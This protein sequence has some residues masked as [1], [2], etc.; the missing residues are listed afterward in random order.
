M[1]AAEPKTITDELLQKVSG[2]IGGSSCFLDPNSYDVVCALAEAKKLVKADAFGAH[3]IYGAIYQGLGDVE[4]M[5]YHFDNA[6]KI[7][8]SVL[9]FEHKAVAEINLGFFSAAQ[10]LLV[11]VANPEL[12][13]FTRAY[14]LGVCCGAFQL[15][16]TYTERAISMR[17]DISG[18][19]TS[20]NLRA[21]KVLDS[22]GVSDEDVAAMLD[23]A[24]EVFRENALFPMGEPEL[25]IDDQGL[26]SSH[27]VYLCFDLD[28]S[29][30]DT[31]RLF[32]RFADKVARRM[33]VIPDAFHLSFKPALKNGN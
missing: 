31:A 14:R 33:S 1:I 20:D 11:R 17:I 19:S 5:R 12:G 28:L 24:G 22:A 4:K 26:E 10:N 13:F 6:S 3:I 8:D 15:L 29:P 25:E 2:L 27:C 21:A 18:I 7:G 9:A 32:D 16:R 30:V 23:L